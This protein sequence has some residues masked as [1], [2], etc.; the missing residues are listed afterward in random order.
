MISGMDTRRASK[1][2]GEQH[3]GLKQAKCRPHTH[4]NR[5]SG[6][7]KRFFRWLHVGR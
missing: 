1:F 4:F 2:D 7:R 3:G 5:L 6:M